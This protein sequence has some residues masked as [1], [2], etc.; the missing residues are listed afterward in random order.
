MRFPGLLTVF[1]WAIALPLYPDMG[2]G[3]VDAVCDA[4]RACGGT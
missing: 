2:E 1:F 3:A 4:L